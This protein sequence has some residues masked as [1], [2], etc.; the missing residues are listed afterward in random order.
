MRHIEPT[1]PHLF[2]VSALS[3]NEQHLISAI[4]DR[5]IQR[6]HIETGRLIPPLGHSLTKRLQNA[7]KRFRRVG[8]EKRANHSVYLTQLVVTSEQ[9]QAVVGYSDG[10]IV[11]W[12]LISQQVV[13]T[14]EATGTVH[15]IQWVPNTQYI[16]FSA[17][18]ERGDKDNVTLWRVV[19]GEVVYTHEN[20]RTATA[21]AISADG[22]FFLQGNVKNSLIVWEIED[23]MI[24]WKKALTGHSNWIRAL[25]VTEDGLV[26]STSKDRSVRIWSLSTFEE[27]GI[28]FFN[29]IFTHIA[30]HG[31]QVVFGNEAG[32]LYGCAIEGFAETGFQSLQSLDVDKVAEEAGYFLQLGWYRH[33]IERYEQLCELQPADALYHRNLG[34]AYRNAGN[35]EEAHNHAEIALELKLRNPHLTSYHKLHEFYGERSVTHLLNHRPSQS[36]NDINEALKLAQTNDAAVTEHRHLRATIFTALG[37]DEQALADLNQCLR[38]QWR[39]SEMF[40]DRGILFLG[41]RQFERAIQDFSDATQLD[42]KNKF[43]FN[44]RGIAY[45]QTGEF[46]RAIAD[47]T[48]A[49]GID[50]QAPDFFFYRAEAKRLLQRFSD[51]LPDYGEA[52]LLTFKSNTEEPVFY[53][54]RAQV[55]RELG[56]VE[57]ARADCYDVIRLMDDETSEIVVSARELLSDLDER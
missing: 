56:R 38:S 29:S 18:D 46:E 42:E 28:A 22:R 53:Y 30:I 20:A 19:D 13:T 50:K 40:V 11:V 35:G 45:H 10:R 36:L 23:A 12:D 8:V 31:K 33:A 51:A 15:T 43:A 55:A 25:A 3:T 6:W 4:P 26:I 34:I 44:G 7:W 41:L 5:P 14:Y 17:K 9:E 21:S 32:D 27:V 1:Q 37:Q 54:R 39:S 57:L 47:Q 49:I 48:S 2:W 52:I 24:K 16:I